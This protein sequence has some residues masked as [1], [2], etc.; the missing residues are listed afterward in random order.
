MKQK[1][2]VGSRA[3][4]GCI[5]GFKSAN[6]NMLE[7]VDNP[8]FKAGK[9]QNDRVTCVFKYT[10]EPARQMIERA[11]KSG[12]PLQAGKFLVPEVAHAIGA[13]IEDIKLLEPLIEQLAQ[14]HNW[15]KII[16]EAYIENH[17]FTLTQDQLQQAYE[18]YCA[19]R[20]QPV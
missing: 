1:F 20:E 7:L 16:Y 9:E 17:S 8:A 14:K 5:D 12:N 10:R 4:F 6:R 18:S 19:N 2:L 11:V 15:Q 13:T 3:F